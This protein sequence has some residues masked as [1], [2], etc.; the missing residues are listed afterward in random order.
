M[1]D[2]FGV[3]VFL[4]FA[5][6]WW[7]AESFLYSSGKLLNFTRYKLRSEN[8]FKWRFYMNNY[9]FFLGEFQMQKERKFIVMST[10]LDYI[11]NKNFFRY[12]N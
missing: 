5:G 7:G 2:K 12:N 8:N 9:F 3:M 10:L 1:I 6:K 4:V 11:Q